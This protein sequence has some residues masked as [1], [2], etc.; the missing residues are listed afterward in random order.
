MIQHDPS[1]TVEKT[2]SGVDKTAARCITA[3]GNAADRPALSTFGISSS[4]VPFPITQ[5]PQRSNTW[6]EMDAL[7][8]D[9]CNIRM[10]AEPG[11][12]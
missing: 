9:N 10:V 12:R 8:E 3:L 4:D 6:S 1:R 2:G 7:L 11:R 5:S